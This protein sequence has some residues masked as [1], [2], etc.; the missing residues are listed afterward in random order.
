MTNVGFSFSSD[1][2]DDAGTCDMIEA[3]SDPEMLCKVDG[4]ADIFNLL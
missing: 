1:D 2:N 3:V 4:G